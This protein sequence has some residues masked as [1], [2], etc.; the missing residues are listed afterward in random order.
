[1]IYGFI[2]TGAITEAI[3]DGMMTSSLDVTKVLVSPR[4]ADVAA[5]LAARFC[6]VEVA[7]S[8]QAV[9]DAAEVLVLAVRPQIAEEVLTALQ[10]AAGRRLIS[11]IAAT[12]HEKL[13]MWTGYDKAQ[14]VR[15]IPLPFVSYR[16]GVTAI[17]PAD[18]TSCDLFSAIGEAVECES[19]NDFDLLSAA[20]STMGVYYGFMEKVAGW[21]VTNGMEEGK[22][23]S[24]LTPLY[25][26][27][28][29]VAARSPDAGYAMLRNKFSTKGGLNE[30]VFRE[31]DD[32]GGSA[33]LLNALDGVLAR[34]RR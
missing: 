32:N 30:Q 20:S 11:V 15:A 12:N 6:K 2:G 24:Y 19:Q 10:I 8:N 18:K 16:D 26:S 3:I 13:A 28:S 5:G 34:I 33:A 4:N 21:L 29:H 9:A 17:F 7:A 31:F 23:H 22:A 14:I 1:M 25:G 27:L